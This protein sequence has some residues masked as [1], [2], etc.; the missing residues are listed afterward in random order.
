M[1]NIVQQR[2]VTSLLT[3]LLALLAQS[4][5]GF[6]EDAASAATPANERAAGHSYHGEAFNEG[7]RQ[8]AYLMG[9][10]GNV[11]FP[12]TTKVPDA[13]KF[14]D[15]GIGQL[16][17]FWYFEAER[18]FRQAAALDPDCAIAYWGMA[19]ANI[20]NETRGRKFLT[21]AISRKDKASP[22]TALHRS[23]RHAL[24]AGWQGRTEQEGPPDRL[25]EG[26]G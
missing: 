4:S 9:G 25:P 8:A 19:L 23:A 17:G 11:S 5:I 1:R 24:Q 14:V 2:Y 26:H 10:T 3:G 21:E 7:P 18:S 15:Q 22:R 12:V 20:N 13:Q 6:C 16:H